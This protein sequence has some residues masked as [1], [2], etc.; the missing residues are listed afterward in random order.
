MWGP[1]S[2]EEMI[3]QTRKM[4][5]KNGEIQD[6]IKWQNSKTPVDGQ[7]EGGK[8]ASKKTLKSLVCKNR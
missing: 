3:I 6:I 4:A 7:Y 8:E 2:Q 5:V 1:Q